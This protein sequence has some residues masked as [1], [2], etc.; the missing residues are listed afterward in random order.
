MHKNVNKHVHVAFLPVHCQQTL[1]KPKQKG[2]LQA[3][4]ASKDKSQ[5]ENGNIK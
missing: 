3:I 4:S 2:Y 5:S 1:S